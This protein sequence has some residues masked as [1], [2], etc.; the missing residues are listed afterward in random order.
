M[1]SLSKA[2]RGTHA[3]RHHSTSHRYWLQWG[4][5]LPHLLQVVCCCLQCCAPELDD[6]GRLAV[7][8]V[9]KQP[10]VPVIRLKLLLQGQNTMHTMCVR[11]L[12]WDEA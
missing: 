1:P 2:V 6:L 7:Q 4:L 8:V 11:W 9:L 3:A 12:P 10:L 5:L